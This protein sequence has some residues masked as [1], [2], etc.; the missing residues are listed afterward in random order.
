MDKDIMRNVGTPAHPVSWL[1]ERAVAL[2]WEQLVREGGLDSP[3]IRDRNYSGEVHA[4]LTPDGDMSEDL[5]KGAK[6][7]D[8]PDDLTPIGGIIPDLALYDENN[9]PIRIIE[10]VVSSAPDAA[11]QAKLDRLQE[12]GVDVVVVHVRTEE[13]L[14]RLCWQP[15]SPK[16]A[17]HRSTYESDIVGNL[18]M[19]LQNCAPKDRRQL[20]DVLDSIRDLDS[21]WPLAKGNPK[22]PSLDE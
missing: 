21:L 9:R 12:R 4:R 2:L 14:I 7:V 3:G 17:S 11:K 1:H 20:L 18:V 8:M 6:R 13:D 10:V 22:A 15:L 19:G 16:W 5:C